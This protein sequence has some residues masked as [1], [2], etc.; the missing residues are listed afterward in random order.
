MDFFAIDF[1]VH[2]SCFSPLG[3]VAVVSEGLH[4]CQSHFMH[5]I[6]A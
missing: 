1:N 4:A 2:G 6:E 5:H 3:Q